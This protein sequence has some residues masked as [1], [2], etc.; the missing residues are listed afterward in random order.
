MVYL[1]VRSVF[2]VSILIFLS[3]FARL[4][5]WLLCVACLWLGEFVSHLQAVE[6]YV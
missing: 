2:G 4:A 6:H 5:A 3:L 1:L